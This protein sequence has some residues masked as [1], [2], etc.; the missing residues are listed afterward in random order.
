MNIAERPPAEHDIEA[1]LGVGKRRPRRIW[2]W[3][4]LAA[5]LGAGAYFMFGQPP[6]AQTVYTT[7]PA[8]RGNLTVTVTA[9]GTLQPRNQVDVSSE[10]SGILRSVLVDDNDTVRAGQVIAELDTVTLTAQVERSRAALASARARVAQSEATI[11]ETNRTFDRTQSLTA[12][13][14]ASEGALDI[15]RANQARAAASRE[16]AQA[17]VRVAEAELKQIETN[18]AKTKLYSPIDGL[19]LKRSAE[20]GQTVASSFQ[21]PVLFTL[22]DDLRR[23]ELQVDVDEADIGKVRAGQRAEFT[24]AAYQER[25]FPAEI[26]SVRFASATINGVVTYKAILSAANDDLALR[27]GMTATAEIV[28]AT[29]TDAVLVPNA[30]LR[31]KPPAPTVQRKS[32]GGFQLFRFPRRDRNPGAAIPKG[33]GRQVYILEGGEPVARTVAIGATDGRQTVIAT[34]ML[35]ADVPVITASR[36]PSDAER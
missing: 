1:I 7:E 14:Y 33:T 25:R 28:V 27:P 34:G 36:G 17:D 16:S 20:P 23:M 18:L 24:V 4:L 31:W 10:L 5:G 21:A 12:R 30:A 26:T 8:V 29:I 2:L 13:Q 3:L 9:T 32:G 15:A 6:A 35:E 19:V 11:A 22:A